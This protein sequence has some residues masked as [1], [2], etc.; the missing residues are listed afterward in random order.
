MKILLIRSNELG[1][2]HETNI[3]GIYP[4]LG[5]GYIASALRKTGYQVSFLDNQILR[6]NSNAIENEIRRINPDVVLLSAMTPL[7]PGLVTLSSLI[8]GISPKI[9]VGIGG[10]HLSAYPR[11][12][13][14]NES[15]DFGVYGEGE[16]AILEILK[17]IRNGKA[18]DDVKGC[19]FRQDGKIIVNSQRDVIGDLDSVPFPD[20]D[21]FPYRKYFALSV[22]QPFF[23]MVTSRG[24]P[25]ACK[26]CFQEYLGR[27]RTR[28]PENVIE[29]MQMLV[30]K[31]KVQEIIIFDETFAVEEE[32]VLK[33]CE[34]IRKKGMRFK[35]DIRT[36]VDLLNVAVLESLKSAGCYRI[37]LGIESGD[38]DILCKMNK[39]FTVSEIIEK[40]NLARKFGFELR[41]YFMFAYPGETYKNIC[42]TIEFAKSLP[43]DWASFTVTIGLPETDIYKE[44]LEDGYF[45][46]DYWREYTKGNILDSKPYFI[47]RGME[48]KDLFML[49]KK[50]YFEFYLRPRIIRNI[51]KSSKLIDVI[52]NF[53]VFFKLLPSV[54]NSLTKI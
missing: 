44:A 23:T 6:L 26:F 13:L 30:D 4:P 31:Y 15:I 1:P 43:L 8:K 40:V 27:Y 48:E 37:N 5:L 21:V 51:L 45:Q 33:I 10:P 52:N 42:E 12:S 20:I 38:Q 36:R 46:I 41:G 49:K 28:S 47:P 22:R 39:G 16:C 19:V 25:Y 29:E 34:L 2:S 14:S 32:R 17:A 3:T 35:W 9:I 53:R 7:W 54:H 24:C 18:L 11:E 50:A